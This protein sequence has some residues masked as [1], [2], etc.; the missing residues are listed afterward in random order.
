LTDI[1]LHLNKL[2]K[3]IFQFCIVEPAQR[4]SFL[5]RYWSE[6]ILFQVMGMIWISN[7][8]LTGWWDASTF[9]VQWG[10]MDINALLT[11]AGINIG[12]C[13]VLFSFYSVLRKQPSNVNVYFGRRLASQ[14]SRR[15]DLCLER[16]VPSPS[17]ILKAW[18]TSEEEIL[19]IG[20]LDGVVF[21][22][23]LVFRLFSSSK[24]E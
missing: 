12:L 21:V 18:E 24:I 6:Y 8:F 1:I 23:M 2:V 7:V 5:P 16:F 11:S 13:V 22:R 15:V 14:H 3:E 9:E 20:G 4:N 19:A 10:G 17:W